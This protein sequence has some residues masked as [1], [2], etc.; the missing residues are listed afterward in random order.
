[1]PN[2]RINHTDPTPPGLQDRT[3]PTNNFT[4][5]ME[6]FEDVDMVRYE[7]FVSAGFTSHQAATVA[8]EFKELI[9]AP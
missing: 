3:H 2:G 1:M 8:R 4:P 6:D 9:G 7:A 5:G